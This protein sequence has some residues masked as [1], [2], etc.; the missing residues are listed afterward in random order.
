MQDLL[1]ARLRAL[2]EPLALHLLEHFVQAVLLP[3]LLAT[4]E[5]V[6]S[7][8]SSPPP[9]AAPAAAAAAEGEEEEEDDDD[10]VGG[11]EALKQV[12][13]FILA[14]VRVPLCFR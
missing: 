5:D 8:P 7:Y 1:G 12:A 9:R 10:D 14:Q 4:Q 6:T 11:L 2:S 13:L 3:A